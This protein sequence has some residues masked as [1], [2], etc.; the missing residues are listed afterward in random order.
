[1]ALPSGTVTLLFTDIQGSTRQ[2]EERGPAMPEALRRQD[3]L[4]RTAI[5][6]HGGHV[7]KT[8]GDAF[9]TVFSRASDA[10][11]AAADAQRALAAEDWSAIG[12]LTVRM[13]VH[14]G[15]TDERDGDYFGATVNRVA[16]L[17]AIAHGGQV[18]VSGSTAA[19]LYGVMPERTE[20]LDLGSHRLKDLVE[21]EHVWQLSVE[22]LHTD[23]PA[24]R[25]L[26]ARP[27]NLPI[28]RTSLV[29]REQDVADVVEL[30]KRY[31]LL[32]LVGSGGVGKTRLALQVGAELF[33][34]YPDGVWFVD[35]API[36]DPELVSSVAARALGIRQQEGRRADEVIPLSLKRKKLLLIFDN[37]EH[38]VEAVAAL[39]AS[40]LTTAP[41]VTILATSRQALDIAGEAAHRL[42]SLP[43]PADVAGLTADDAL[44]YGAIVLFVDRARAADTRFGLSDDTAPII[45]E[46]CRRLD[47]IP[48]AI[49]LAAARV[50]VLSISNI[51]QR[52]NERFRILTGGGRDALPRQKTLSALID[53]SYDLLT[54]QEQ[55]LF[56][57]L[58]VFAG[59]FGLNSA[60]SICGGEGL[61]A[62]DILD[63]L[64][65]LTDKSL[66]V[67]DTSAEHER[68]RLLE[69]TA[70]YALEKLSASGEHE[71]LARRHAE[72]FRER[73]RD[74]DE[75][76]GTGS[77]F[78]WVAELELE[79]DNHRAALEWALTHGNDVVLGGAIAGAI[80]VLWDYA[81]LAIEGR[82]WIEL[83]LE[84]VSE[85]EQPH[86]AGSLWYAL[87][88]VT[89]GQRKHDAAKRAV[90]LCASVSDARGTARAQGQLAFALLQMGRLDEADAT[91]EQALARAR[92]CGDTVNLGT[93]IETQAS[94][95]RVRG[96]IRAARELY[97][98]ALAAYKV[99]GNE[100]GIATALGN[101]AELEF[102]DGQPEQALRVSSEAL[103]ILLRGK[104]A[105]LIAS[106][107]TN[108]VAYR[109]ALGDLG[110]ARD[111]AREG[112]LAALQARYDIY[113]AVALQH[114]ALLAG[115]AGDT[116]C[117]AHLLGYVDAQFSALGMRR[118]HTE[119]WSYDKL[120]TALR[121]TLSA[122][123]IAQL[124]EAG[125]TWSEDQAVEVALN[126]NP[127]LSCGQ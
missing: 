118:E 113:I 91:N 56:A 43:L 49:E 125:A 66:V 88:Y 21:P 16:R 2:W 120:T 70:V 28:Q 9:C 82:D 119:Q 44:Q 55:L 121:E 38:V 18:V 53:W 48:L 85:A 60:T 86:I 89:S 122:D 69:S 87:A 77:T 45:A 101:I 1:M 31:R 75:R 8:I 76:Y 26:D 14:S 13:A 15:A 117:A 72:Y 52:L 106:G 54:S 22:T 90:R 112:L 115:L 99:P 20:L 116:H 29:G 4:L 40:I 25:S 11:A 51:A 127:T 5:E 39:A 47:G 62:I 59:G 104:N 123:E 23:F 57:R 109:I 32:T 42:P 93:Y 107:Y 6:A 79:L 73:A 27:N 7:F 34:D 124:T 12:G 3:D 36:S 71:A 114:L 81:G 94:I 24:L 84:Q 103:E 105:T 108:N 98:Q 37:C 68:Y 30:L 92:A 33:D 110:A 83:A 80:V 63:L 65:S 61:D 58:G 10:A 41:E 17:L 100:S 111:P 95:A 50:K 35:L 97:A 74:A 126:T 78:A 46:I 19:L 96:D 67:A 64:G 102:A